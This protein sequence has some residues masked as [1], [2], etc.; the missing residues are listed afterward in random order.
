LGKEHDPLLVL[1]DPNAPDFSLPELSLPQGIS[2]ERLGARRELQR[3]IDQQSRLLDHSAAARGID[4]YYD[5]A[6]AMLQSD[7]LRRAFDLS[8]EPDAVRDR[9]GRTTYRQGLI[10]ARRLVEAGVKFVTVYF[11]DTIGGQSTDGG[12][13]DTH[14][15]NNT[16]MFPIVEKYHLPITDL[17]LPVFLTD[18][19]ERGLLDDTLVVWMGEFGRTPELNK[20]TSRDHWPHCYT[21]LLGRGRREAG[22]RSR[23]QRPLRHVPG[24]E[25][26]PPR[27]PVS[28]DLSPPGHRSAHR[29]PEP[30]A[31]PHPYRPGRGRPRSDRVRGCLAR[32]FHTLSAAPGCKP[33]MFHYVPGWSPGSV[34]TFIVDA[35][36]VDRSPAVTG[37]K[38]CRA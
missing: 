4:A 1:R 24:G 16:H 15:F 12:G 38:G 28:H 13:W 6:L 21:A 19:D 7:R 11:S 22:I 2:V 14:G 20:Q 37:T 26:R 30:P 8:G 25:T 32:I 27:G 18:L 5:R 35:G 29:D 31:T 36:L 34:V 33:I 3:L 9:F 23:R 17:T 10:L